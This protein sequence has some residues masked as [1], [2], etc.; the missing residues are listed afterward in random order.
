MTRGQAVETRSRRGIRLATFR[1]FRL[2]VAAVGLGVVIVVII[3]VDDVVVLV[4]G[5][6]ASATLVSSPSGLE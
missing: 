2:G 4:A 6:C 1:I 3:V 5:L